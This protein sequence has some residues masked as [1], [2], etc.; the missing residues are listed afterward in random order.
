MENVLANHSLKLNDLKKLA[1]E[2]SGF[3]GSDS[4]IQIDSDILELDRQLS[5]IIDWIE[6]S[7]NIFE[8][9]NKFQEA[10]KVT[11]KKSQSLINHVTEDLQLPKTAEDEEHLVLLRSHLL[12]IAVIENELKNQT[13]IPA[14]SDENN[15]VVNTLS[16]LQKL[17]LRTITEYNKL[18]SHLVNNSDNIVIFKI[19]MDYLNHVRSFLQSPIPSDY[20]LLKEQLHLC[21]IHQKLTSNQRN[22]LMHKASQES[23]VPEAFNDIMNK[24]IVILNDLL[25]RQ[26]ETELRLDAWEKCRIGQADLLEAIEDIER[27][28]SL[29]KLKQVFLKS[30]PGQKD[31][32]RE[33]L[34][35]ISSAESSITSFKNNQ[36]DLL[37]F[38]DDISLSS[39]RLEF[40]TNHQ[41]LENIRASLETWLEFLVR[42][43]DLNKDYD[44]KLKSIQDSLQYGQDF[45]YNFKKGARDTNF[46]YSIQVLKDKQ[47]TLEVVKNDLEDIDAI[48][49]EMR[50]YISTYDFKRI[51]QS[52]WTLWQQY[53]D[54]DYE[55]S[56]FINQIE[57]QASL[58]S[59]FNE[60]YRNLMF[61]LNEAEERL[62]KTLSHSDH[63]SQAP[64][65][66]SSMKHYAMRNLEEF[67]I[68][69]YDR[70]W[71]QSVGS[72]LL[73]FYSAENTHEKVDIENKLEDMNKKW[74]SLK[75]LYNN[76]SIR[77]G[78]NKTT[79]YKL[80][81]RIGKIRMW[82]FETEKALLKPFSF[83]EV[84]KASFEK[85]LIEYEKI[86][87]SVE[88]QSSN[89][90][91][92]LNLS[93]MILS[94]IYSL[95]LDTKFKDLDFAINNIEQRWKKICES[96]VQRKCNLLAIWKAL[97]ELN[98]NTTKEK[99]V[100]DCDELCNTIEL[101]SDSRLSKNMAEENIIQLNEYLERTACSA[102]TFA[103]LEKQ[104]NTVLTAN[105]D[106]NN[107]RKITFET[108]RLLNI[109]KVISLRITSNIRLLENYLDQY[110]SFESQHRNLVLS[111]TEFDLEI[112]SIN[113]D[114]TNVLKKYSA[115]KNSLEFAEATRNSLMVKSSETERKQLKSMGDEYVK[116]FE[117]IQ[118]VYNEI[119]QQN[120]NAVKA[121][122][123]E[124]KDAAVQVNTMH[125]QTSVSPK[126]AYEYEIKSAVIELRSN[127]NG[128]ERIISET[129]ANQAGGLSK[130]AKQQAGKTF[131]ACESTIELIKYLNGLLI[132]DYGCTDVEACTREAEE[133]NERYQVCLRQ[134]NL[135]KE[136]KLQ[137]YQHHSESD[138]KS[139]PFCSQR[140]WEQIDNDLWRLEQWLHVAEN[141]GRTQTT[142]PSN[143][144]DLEDV[145]QDH[146]EFL[147]NLDSHKSIISS[148]NTV[149][150]H[151][152]LHT[153]DTEKASN[154]RMRLAQNG[155]R[156]DN[157]CKHAATWQSKLQESLIANRE[158]HRIINEFNVWLEETERKIKHFE[159]VDLA[160]EHS[161]LESKFLR[162]KELKHEIERCEPRVISLQENSAQL[163]KSSSKNAT[164]NETYIK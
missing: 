80:E 147:L 49:D 11:V 26:K 154:L 34:S 107:I 30:L 48:K 164:A 108:K 120:E 142:P 119:V 122:V 3:V 146:R 15:S 45:L 28:K 145:I 130:A 138:W 141:E 82:L 102:K 127:I 125:A 68:K 131:A 86:Q 51:R 31:Q 150:E 115:L 77:I 84:N 1:S 116:L 4:L 37:R 124:E 10:R 55:Y 22:A 92:I 59:E 33:I 117:S 25:E 12:N 16:S 24:H 159:P 109:W 42:I 87:R 52:S 65:H 132:T 129:E 106:I 56:L 29:L 46:M 96:L 62:T 64:E 153:S 157:I 36:A 67:A 58:Q 74:N 163:L 139:C 81:A 104:F 7:K 133:L 97:E 158:F 60:R 63:P 39:L 126:D 85:Q 114:I 53:T 61:W 151:L 93:E 20:N 9:S 78:E 76:R 66:S 110:K 123:V 73:H 72:E 112:N 152:A 135:K 103:L 21:K 160:S 144:E 88:N 27:E 99:W 121:Q 162:F 69:E 113:L 143:I 140:N 35:K 155:V 2:I 111:L 101:Q 148:L 149:G 89:I 95:D 5:E 79:Y 18:S 75:A 94:E 8:H 83:E 6:T 13:N 71:I 57:E 54:L 50:S 128:L 137:A 32:I 90:A 105:V 17:F 100:V 70:K 38:A 14:M 19:W 43:E 136:N 41:R 118:L 44:A 23:L 47:K 91:E 161:L 98:I 40:S 156:W 134:W